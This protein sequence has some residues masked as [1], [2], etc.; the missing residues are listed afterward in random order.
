MISKWFRNSSIKRY[1][2]RIRNSWKREQK[3]KILDKLESNVLLLTTMVI[4]FSSEINLSIII[5]SL[6]ICTLRN[7]NPNL[8]EV[9]F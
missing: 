6:R 5:Y 4:V 9:T 8:L 1:S 7:F 3:G 2:F